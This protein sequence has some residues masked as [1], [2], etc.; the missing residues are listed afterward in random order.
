MHHA[1]L[2]ARSLARS[3]DLSRLTV[4][5]FDFLHRQM[6]ELNTDAQPLIATYEKKGQ[7]Q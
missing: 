7:K 5:H 6:M 3:L 1:Q 4:C 2:L